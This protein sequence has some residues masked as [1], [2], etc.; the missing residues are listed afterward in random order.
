MTRHGKTGTARKMTP[1]QMHE[2]GLR[3]YG[4]GRMEEALVQFWASLK[5]KETSERWNDWAAAQHALGFTLQAETGF[6]KAFELDKSNLLAAANL[7]SLLVAH[8]RPI[9]AAPFLLAALRTTDDV[10]RSGVKD[11]ISR[12]SKLNSATSPAAVS[13]KQQIRTH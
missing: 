3:L 6:R 2:Q 1:K 5:A 4:E 12:I 10:L 9:E 8:G 11:V 13:P 7:G